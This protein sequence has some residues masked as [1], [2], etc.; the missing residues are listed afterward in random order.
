MFVG[1]RQREATP[2]STSSRT[3]ARAVAL[4]S[5]HP[6]ARPQG[7]ADGER[8]TRSAGC[9]AGAVLRSFPTWRPGRIACT[10]IGGPLLLEP[11]WERLG[12]AAV[13]KPRCPR[14][15]RGESAGQSRPEPRKTTLGIA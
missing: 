13:L 3:S 11:I 9:L 5:D 7:R 8:R 15:H 1:E 4:A 12:V 2:T 10:R 14:Q 6:R